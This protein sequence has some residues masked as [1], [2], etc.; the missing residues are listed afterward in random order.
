MVLELARQVEQPWSVGMAFGKCDILLDEEDLLL[1]DILGSSDMSQRDLAL[2]FLHGRA[3]V[4][5]QTWLEGIQG[6]EIVETWTPQQRADF[7]RCLPFCA[8]TWDALEATDAETQHLYWREVAIYG[9]GDMPTEGCERAVMKFV[10]Y[11]RLGS[12]VKFLSLHSWMDDRRFGSQ[13]IADVLEHV[14]QGAT[15]ETIDWRTLARDVSRLLGI[16]QDSGEIDDV[17]MARLEWFFLP[18]L[19]HAERKPK[20]LHRTLAEDPSFFVE[21]L[22][23]VYKSEDEEPREVSEEQQMRALLA[24]ELLDSWRQ[25][26]GLGEDGAVDA[27]KVRAWLNRARELAAAR[28]RGAAGDHHIGQVFIYYPQGADGAW[29]HEAVRDLLE[30]VASEHIEPTFKGCVLLRCVYEP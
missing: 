23:C 26:P 5:G 14:V 11:G 3:A 15:T 8:S 12:A 7:Y 28:G 21:V 9:H 30:E 24:H 6:R 20:A 1:R 25:P 16:L 18:L 2:G 10:E 4:R 17:R 13:R 29:P 22:S 27:E 19:H